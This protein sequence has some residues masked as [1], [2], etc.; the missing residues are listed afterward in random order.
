LAYE[1][2]AKP[3]TGRSRRLIL[4]VGALTLAG[5]SA[6]L[7]WWFTTLSGLPD[8]GDPFDVAAF[9]DPVIPD[10]ENAFVL[11]R[12][13]VEK[14]EKN[15]P[16]DMTYHWET[17]GLVEKAWLERSREALEI[18][19]RGTERPK[20]LYVPPKT[21]TVMTLLPVVQESR[22]FARLA[23]LEGGR[24]EAEGDVEGAWGWYRAMFRCSRHLGQRGTAIERLVGRA[25]HQVASREI[26]RWA[27]DPRVTPPMLRKALDAVIADGAM[28]A[29]LSDCVKV[30]YLGFLNTYAD[31]D[32]VRKCLNDE[33]LGATKADWVVRNAAVF[34]MAKGIKKEPERSRRVI[35]LIYANLL[36]ACDLPPERRPPI[37]SSVANLSG[38][39]GPPILVDLYRVDNSASPAARA[40]PPDE[41]VN[42]YRTTLYASR[43]SPALKMVFNAVDYERVAQANLVLALANRLYEIE[44]GKPAEKVEDLVGPYLKSLPDG[45]KPIE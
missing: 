19:R 37:V 18:W 5:T 3:A 41:I 30:E 26:T 27:N 38:L 39:G 35:R 43:L 4:V 42:W 28:V 40:L 6:F 45:Y 16:A 32:L 33:G 23:Q 10:D 2:L 34:S 1:A 25:V 7:S 20:A 15:E 12:E 9:C 13:A 36:S 14:L 11:Y 31:A 8:V 44:R 22:T 17:A 24:L 29:P 21:V